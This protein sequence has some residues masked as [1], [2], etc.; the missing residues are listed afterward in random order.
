MRTPIYNRLICCL[1]A[2]MVLAG[3]TGF[4]VIEH[5]CQMRGHSKSSL[6]ASK[7]CVKPCQASDDEAATTGGPVVKRMACCKTTLSYEHLDV[8]NF[9]LDHPVAPVS[10]LAVYCPSPSF[11][12]L[13]ATLLPPTTAAVSLPIAD[14]SLYRTGRFRLTSLCSWLI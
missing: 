12:W 13:L 9:A 6:L 10:P 14:D 3:S 2:V 4:G 5:W 8:S 1:L 11:T 7:G